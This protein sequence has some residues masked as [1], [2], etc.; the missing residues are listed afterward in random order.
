[1]NVRPYRQDQRAR[2]R[3]ET[4]ARIVGAAEGLYRDAWYDEVT[5]RDVA[6]AAD[7]AVQTVVN[8]F[9]TKANLFAA[10]VERVGRRV[11]AR[12]D[13]VVAGDARGGITALVDEYEDIGDAI[14]RMLALEERVPELS[15][16]LTQGRAVHRAWVQR[17][18]ADALPPGRGAERDRRTAMLVVATDVL[19]WKLLRRDQGL[20][21]R[22]A[23]RAMGEMAQA[24]FERPEAMP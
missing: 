1:M 24:L 23:E 7:V 3:E 16:L 15:A 13:A 2:A 10:V 22:A 11:D 12:R 18:F 6:R 9:G 19:S 14:V 8:H 17:V 20:S 21:R 5:L 4:R